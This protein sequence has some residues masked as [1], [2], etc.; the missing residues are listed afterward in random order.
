MNCPNCVLQ[1]VQ[2]NL[3]GGQ[4]DQQGKTRHVLWVPSLFSIWQL[5]VNIYSILYYWH[6]QTV[7]SIM[8]SDFLSYNAICLQKE[9]SECQELLKA[10]ESRCA[11]L[12]KEKN[13]LR[14]GRTEAI[15]QMKVRQSC[16][17]SP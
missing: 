16:Y 4:V 3:E 6:N 15:E 10:S 17:L 14:E 7:L 1:E 8:S 9:L 13:L 2:V 5:N 12:H 11:A